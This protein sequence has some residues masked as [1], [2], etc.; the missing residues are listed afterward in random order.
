MAT[1]YRTIGDIMKKIVKVLE[2]IIGI[3][4]MLCLFVS[5]LG[6]IGY[7]VALGIGGETAVSICAWLKN[8]FYKTL[9]LI[10]NSTVLLVFVYIYL[11]NSL[12][13]RTWQAIVIHG[14]AKRWT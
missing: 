8:Y 6:F 7:M 1:N 2:Y 14:V 5:V 12:D 9:I 4:F 3:S 13:R 10:S 11:E